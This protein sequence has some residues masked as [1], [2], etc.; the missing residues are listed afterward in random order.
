MT[1]MS[2]DEVRNRLTPEALQLFRELVD[3]HRRSWR[4]DL[5]PVGQHG[6]ERADLREPV[7]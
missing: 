4:Q 2:Y 5:H 7:G 6:R 1:G 3:V